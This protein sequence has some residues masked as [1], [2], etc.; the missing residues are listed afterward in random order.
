M[1]SSQKNYPCLSGQRRAMGLSKA[2]YR[3]T[4]QEK[5]KKEFGKASDPRPIC[6]ESINL[7]GIL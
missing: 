3:K 5:L 6:A 7:R 2:G 1:A 4:E